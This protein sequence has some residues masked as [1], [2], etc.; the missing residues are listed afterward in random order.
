MPQ[1]AGI[2]CCSTHG[3]K[4]ILSRRHAQH[5]HAQHHWYPQG[6]H[7]CLSRRCVNSRCVNSCQANVSPACWVKIWAQNKAVTRQV[8]LLVTSNHH[9]CRANSVNAHCQHHAT[10]L[11]LQ[12][13]AVVAA[14]GASAAVAVIVLRIVQPVTQLLAAHCRAAGAGGRAVT[15]RPDRH[16]D[17][18]SRR[19]RAS[20]RRVP[21]AG[22]CCTWK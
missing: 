6:A 13:A 16:N 2:A 14:P 22:A 9:Y 18:N 21:A 4:V 11:L 20:G 7:K 5:H 10:G 8:G 19:T 17:H 12:L 15:F 3:V 1:H